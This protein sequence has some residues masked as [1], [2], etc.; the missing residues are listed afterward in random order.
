MIHGLP[1]VSGSVCVSFLDPQRDSIY[2]SL[3]LVTPT[4]LSAVGGSA[5][6]S[7]YNT[8][9]YGALHFGGFGS[10]CSI[11]MAQMELADNF[12][13]PGELGAATGPQWTV[14]KLKI[15]CELPPRTCGGILLSFCGLSFR[16]TLGRA[17]RVEVPALAL[18]G[19]VLHCLLLWTVTYIT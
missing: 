1:L 4:C 17:G 16:C 13:T 6:L 18:G 7:V 9:S 12:G 10:L 14:C 8:L 5:L 11:T 2:H 19:I 3:A 15:A